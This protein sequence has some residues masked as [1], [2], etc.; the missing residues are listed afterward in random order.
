MEKKKYELTGEWR[1]GFDGEK[2]YRIVAMRDI[3]VHDVSKGDMGG[4]VSGYGNLSQIGD[5]W[6]AGEAIVEGE[7]YVCGD[8]WVAGKARIFGKSRLEEKAYVYRSARVGNSKLKGDCEVY[9]TAILNSSK[10][11]GKVIIKGKA[12]LMASRLY[13][14]ILVKDEVFLMET[15]VRGKDIYLL[16]KS[17]IKR[18][19]IGDITEKTHRVTICGEPKLHGV[20]VT[21]DEILIENFVSLDMGVQLA[22]TDIRLADHVFLEGNVRILSNSHIRDVVQVRNTKKECLE[23]GEVTLQGDLELGE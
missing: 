5:S 10:I 22:G 12:E 9:G 23:Y 4:F 13:G 2:V 11:E 16:G 14:E 17:V 15:V 20:S 1:K 18:T 21:G 3:P 7:A 19:T 6:V 8:A